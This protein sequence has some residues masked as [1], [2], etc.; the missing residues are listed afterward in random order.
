M[1]LIKLIV[2]FAIGFGIALVIGLVF[3]LGENKTN[4][5]VRCPYCNSYNTTKISNMSKAVSSALIGVHAVARNSKEWHC[6]N[7]GSDF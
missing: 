5:S 4:V 7:C 6:N 1:G 2:G 3:G